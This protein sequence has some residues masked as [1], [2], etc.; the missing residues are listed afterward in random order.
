MQIITLGLKAVDW[1]F[2][3][4]SARELVPLAHQYLKAIDAGLK[5]SAGVLV[6]VAP[7]VKFSKAFG[8]IFYGKMEYLS[9]TDIYLKVDLFLSIGHATVGNCQSVALV[10]YVRN[11]LLL[12]ISQMVGE[13]KVITFNTGFEI[14]FMDGSMVVV[15]G[16]TAVAS[17]I[18]IVVKLFRC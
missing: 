6:Q 14:D 1:P 7:S 13:N 18:R 3:I 8:G 9:D 15:S 4:D 10:S 5:S 11:D 12:R 2:Y 16:C 17:T